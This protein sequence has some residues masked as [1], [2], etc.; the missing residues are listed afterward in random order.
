MIW[1]LQL[2]EGQLRKIMS[3]CEQF[4][5]DAAVLIFVF[6]LLDTIVQFGK[7]AITGKLVAGTLAISGVFFIWA[8]I[9]GMMGAKGRE[10]RR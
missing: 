8:L 2:D 3:L 1:K 6:P 10:K 9:L 7:E 5:L 4:L